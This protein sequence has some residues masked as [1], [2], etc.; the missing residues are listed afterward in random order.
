MPTSLI[1]PALALSPFRCWITWPDADEGSPL[2]YPDPDLG[3]FANLADA[4][5]QGEMLA[6]LNPGAEIHVSDALSNR[7]TH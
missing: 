7:V 5:E 4:V 6:G 1:S 2:R 3:V